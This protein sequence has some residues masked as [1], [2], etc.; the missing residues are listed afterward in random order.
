MACAHARRVDA[1]MKGTATGAQIQP[2]PLPVLDC[3]NVWLC[4]SHMPE[5]YWHTLT[6]THENHYHSECGKRGHPMCKAMEPKL[7]KKKKKSSTK[8][9]QTVQTVSYLKLAFQLR[10]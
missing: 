3:T 8:V 6:H 9:V 1:K 2:L 7:T 5:R 10:V 4:R